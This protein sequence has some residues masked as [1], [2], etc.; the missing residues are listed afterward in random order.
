MK[1]ERLIS[2]RWITFFAY[3]LVWLGCIAFL[4]ANPNQPYLILVLVLLSL[5]NILISLN[6]NIKDEIT[7]NRI[8]QAA[9]IFD[10][11]LLF[12]VLYFYGGFTNPLSVMFLL[13]TGVASFLLSIVWTWIIFIYST[14]LYI[15]TFIYFIPIPAL[16]HSDHSS[17]HSHHA[18]V[19][20]FLSAFTLHL[21]GMLFSFI[22]TGV[23]L[24]LFLTKMRA[25]I[26]EQ[27]KEIVNFQKKT[28][29]SQALTRIAALSAQSA[30]ELSSPLTTMGLIVE[31]LIEDSNSKNSV[32]SLSN[33]KAL[34]EKCADIVR[35]I[36]KRFSDSIDEKPTDF[37]ITDLFKNIFERFI[38]TDR[39]IKIKYLNETQNLKCFL[40]IKGLEQAIS[41]I[42]DNAIKYTYEDIL[43]YIDRSNSIITIEIQST[44]SKNIDSVEFAVDFM[45]LSQTN[46]SKGLG[47]GIFLT[48]QFLQ[49]IGG[50]LIYSKSK[51][52][53]LS[54]IIS[55]KYEQ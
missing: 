24:V 38:K 22:I 49:S 28:L 41:A 53:K 43:I 50:D 14:V 37:Y 44:S 10:V 9:L 25:K 20:N 51:N 7:E 35:K 12:G 17:H 33:L 2:I 36:R 11:T 39:N 29:A 54:A 21:Y 18:E 55:F 13:Y 42:I 8:I 16:T 1:I 26:D 27:N 47:I 31:D 34:I 32:D 3:L 5:S 30:H 4:K 46:E 6:S 40:P 23:M 19:G 48:R 52:D 45:P 15:F